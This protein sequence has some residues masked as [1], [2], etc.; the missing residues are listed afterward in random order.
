MSCQVPESM[1]KCTKLHSVEDV[2]CRT[3]SNGKSTFKTKAVGI[4]KHWPTDVG[5]GFIQHLAVRGVPDSFPT[6]SAP[7]Q[8][9][10]VHAARNLVDSTLKKKK[11]V[12]DA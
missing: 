11:K 9:Y 1:H 6:V 5:N 8:H 7:E 10:N 4:L 2:L 3:S 12:L